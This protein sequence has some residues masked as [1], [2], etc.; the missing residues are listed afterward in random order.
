MIAFLTAN[1]AAIITILFLLSEL[2]GA[3]PSVKASGV[4][5]AIFNVL[6]SLKDKVSTKD[7][8]SA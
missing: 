4:F 7:T 3:I 2:L 6:K 8:P 1:Y 5:Q